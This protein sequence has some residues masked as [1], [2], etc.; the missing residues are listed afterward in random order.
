MDETRPDDERG[1]FFGKIRGNDAM[2]RAREKTKQ[3]SP[4]TNMHQGF[5]S[6][7]YYIT[8]TKVFG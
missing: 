6:A 8:E 1:S 2:S 4:R 3:R 5:V 7:F